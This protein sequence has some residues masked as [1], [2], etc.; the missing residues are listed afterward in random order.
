MDKNDLIVEKYCCLCNSKVNSFL[1]LGRDRNPFLAELKVIGSDPYNFYCPEC[2]SFDRERHLWLYLNAAGI[3]EAIENQ[4]IL[5]FAPEEKLIQ[6]ILEKTKDAVIA[7]YCPERYSGRPYETVKAD[8]TEINYKDETFD[9]VIANHV[10]EHV[11]D[12]TRAM[13]EIF[14]VLKYDG[15]AILQ[16][17]YSPVI[18]NNFEDPALDTAELREKYY[19]ET[20][21]YRIFGKRFF[22]DLAAAGFQ[23]YVLYHEDILKDFD[24]S[25]YGVNIREPFMFVQK[26]NSK[27]SGSDK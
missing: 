11:E 4:K 8:I 9:M 7:D 25:E 16:T 5:Y 15:I 14:R 23:V 26:T 3:Y 22:D 6:K 24:A 21:H 17:P 18:Y 2:K 20:D 10:L 1:P 13:K 12:Y 27:L 19:G